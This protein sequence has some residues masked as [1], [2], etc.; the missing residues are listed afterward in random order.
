M[1]ILY[2]YNISIMFKN[3]QIHLIVYDISRNQGQKG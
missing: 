1:M 3:Q 2:D